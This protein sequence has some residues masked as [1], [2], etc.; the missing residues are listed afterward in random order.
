MGQEAT[1]PNS[2][3]DKAL[4]LCQELWFSLFVLVIIIS[5]SFVFFTQSS[6]FL[7]FLY[8]NT[9]SFDPRIVADDS[10]HIF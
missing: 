4:M 6:A 5:L 10:K 3:S 9:I 2:N 1:Y 7:N 8:L